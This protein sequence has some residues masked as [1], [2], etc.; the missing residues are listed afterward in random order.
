MNQ[1]QDAEMDR[2]VLRDALWFGLSLGLI[3]A[4]YWTSFR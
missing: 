3:I 2:S 1:S 4:A